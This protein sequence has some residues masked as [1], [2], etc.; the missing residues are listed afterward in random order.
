MK[1]HVSDLWCRR[2]GQNLSRSI[3]AILLGLTGF[4]IP[5]C[6]Y[7]NNPYWVMGKQDAN[8][9]GV[10]GRTWV[11]PWLIQDMVSESNHVSSF[12]MYG[13]GSHYLEAGV[14]KRTIEVSMGQQAPYAFFV[15]E[16][17]PQTGIQQ[18]VWQKPVSVNRRVWVQIDN[19]QIYTGAP[20][21]WDI[22]VDGQMIK[23]SWYVYN[24]YLANPQTLAERGHPGDPNTA[25]F[26]AIKNKGS[27]MQW[28]NWTS[29]RCWDSDAAYD[30]FRISGQA[31]ECRR[32]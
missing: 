30:M 19:R 7:A 15:W 17:Y 14:R 25:A 32:I 31:W 13:D 20:S 22:R 3:V 1:L 28:R 18:D 21:L 8:Y 4:V 9:A 29:I 27:D 23:S 6:A 12:Y 26:D 24:T 10:V 2:C 5:T 16:N 11:Y